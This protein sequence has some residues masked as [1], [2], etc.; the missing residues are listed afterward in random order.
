MSKPS[1]LFS[2]LWVPGLKVSFRGP[3]VS[4]LLLKCS[5]INTLGNEPFLDFQSKRA[6]SKCPIHDWSPVNWSGWV[7]AEHGSFYLE[8]KLKGASKYIDIYELEDPRYTYETPNR[9]C[10]GR[11]SQIA[12]YS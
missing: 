3:A 1:E 12:G 11:R 9:S 2:F 10:I 4:A 7:P 5:S 6:F 8:I